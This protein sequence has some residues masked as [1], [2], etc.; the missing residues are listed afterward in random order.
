MEFEDTPLFDWLKKNRIFLL[1]LLVGII[2]IAAYERFGPALRDKAQIESWTLFQTVTSGLDLDEN[3]ASSLNLARENGRIYPW[4]VFGATKAA[5]LQRNAA[6]LETLKPELTT[7]ASDGDAWQVSSPSGAVS[8][9]SFLLERVNELET[10]GSKEFANPAPTGA[11]VRLV[12][13]DSLETTY[14]L[15]IGTFEDAAPASTELFLSAVEAGTFNGVTIETFGGRT[16]KVPGLDAESGAPLE[17][18]FGYFHLAGSVGMIQKPASP[19]EHEADGIQIMLEDNTFADGTSTV[20][21]DITEGLE[22]LKAAIQSAEADTT[23]TVT[24]ATIL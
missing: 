14:G 16:L 21:G 9:A 5:L 2:G 13:T 22:D 1:V 3:L 24:S 19:G 15:T 20:F 23:F 12:V 8:I 7:L 11:S 6:A 4:V 18:E 10:G 17:R